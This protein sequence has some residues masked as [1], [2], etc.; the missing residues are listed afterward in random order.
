MNVLVIMEVVKIIVSIPLAHTFAFVEMATNWI[1]M[2]KAVLVREEKISYHKLTIIA[3]TKYFHC[4]QISMNVLVKMEVV[5]MFA[6][7]Q[8]AHSV[9][10]V[11]KATPWIPTG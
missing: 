6:P 5:N 11:E 4:F 8:V 2:E 10:L 1:P 9:A 3:L 7:I